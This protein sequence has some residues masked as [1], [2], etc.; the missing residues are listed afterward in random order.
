MVLVSHGF[1]GFL[2]LAILWSEFAILRFLASGG[3]GDASSG[4]SD[5]LADEVAIEIFQSSCES[6]G[7]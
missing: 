4:I 3:P 5:D 6:F 2:V 7:A 1:S